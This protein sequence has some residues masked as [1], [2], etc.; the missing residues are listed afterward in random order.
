MDRYA[1][2][3]LGGAIGSLARYL[4]S[5][6]IMTRFTGRFP[7]GTWVV[8]M[9]GCFFIGLLMTQFTAR[10]AHP[11]WRLLLVV[12]VLG[13]FTTFS[14][15]EYETFTSAQNGAPLVALWNIVASVVCGYLAVWLGVAVAAKS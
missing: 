1:L 11:N 8:N 15:F 14:S 7:L 10:G 2:V 12:G 3:L 9:T 13:G 4:A 5:T 6:A